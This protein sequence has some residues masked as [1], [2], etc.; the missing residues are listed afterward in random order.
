MCD[1][2]VNFI[3][4]CSWLLNIYSLVVTYVMATALMIMVIVLREP[5]RY[6][7]EEKA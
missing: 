5:A 1:M 4:Q 6:S 2:P 7:G 3:I